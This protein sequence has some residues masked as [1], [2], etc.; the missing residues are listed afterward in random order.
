MLMRAN[1]PIVCCQYPRAEAVNAPL[2]RAF[3]GL[4]A[5]DFAYRSH[6][7][8]GRFENLYL[9]AGQLPGVADIL[10]FAVEQARSWL[11][12]AQATWLEEPIAA[13]QP[14][15]AGFWVNAMQPGQATSRH[16]HQECDEMA[17]GVYYV[18]TPEAA[19]DILFHDGPFETRLRPWP[20]LLL[21]FDPALEHSVERNR[22]TARRLSIA[23]NIGP[24]QS[25]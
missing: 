10:A 18:S 19:G 24:S 9:D 11:S 8:D 14:L 15:R 25:A 3:D 17:S 7:I 5:G 23:F 12:S 6:F 22:G 20:G 2:A 13:Q 21:L 16:A 1:R 4:G